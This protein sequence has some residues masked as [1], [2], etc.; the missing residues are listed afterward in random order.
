[1]ISIFHLRRDRTGQRAFD[2]AASL[3]PRSSMKGEA[4][5][6]GAASGLRPM[7]NNHGR[8][9]QALRRE[10]PS[11]NTRPRCKAIERRAVQRQDLCA[12]RT[13]RTNANTEA[14]S[15]TAPA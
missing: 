15:R 9:Q 10:G 5:L 13:G 7:A 8:K 11:E 3:R 12:Q 6:S 14:A 2:E 4:V 1:M